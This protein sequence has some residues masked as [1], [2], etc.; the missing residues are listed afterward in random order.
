MIKVTLELTKPQLEILKE[1]LDLNR[2]SIQMQ[3]KQISEHLETA[4]LTPKDIE[5]LNT[6]VSTKL[7]PQ[8]IVISDLIGLLE[9]PQKEEKSLIIT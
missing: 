7:I 5:Q 3:H 1:I 6:Y 9:N 4:V 2:Q 8:D